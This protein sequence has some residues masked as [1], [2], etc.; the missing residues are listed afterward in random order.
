MCMK[1]VFR[2]FGAFVAALVLC[3]ALSVPALAADNSNPHVSAELTW[4]AFFY[5][6]LTGNPNQVFNPQKSVSAPFYGSNSAFDSVTGSLTSPIKRVFCYP[7]RF[8]LSSVDW[9]SGAIGLY[10]T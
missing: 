4:S 5:N 3:F 2:R 7:R 1:N 10:D 6:S 9:F 8:E